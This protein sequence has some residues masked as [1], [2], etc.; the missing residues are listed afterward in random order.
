[1]DTTRC[2]A[3]IG[4]QETQFEKWNTRVHEVAH[5]KSEI[6]YVITRNKIT[7][8][9]NSIKI[10][11]RSIWDYTGMKGRYNDIHI[12][13]RLGSNDSFMSHDAVMWQVFDVFEIRVLPI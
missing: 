7:L 3:C 6:E 13:I 5:S 4:Y 11:G 8:I 10:R 2:G 1:M 12:Q 9:C